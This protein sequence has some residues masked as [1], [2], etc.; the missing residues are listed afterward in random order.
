MKRPTPDVPHIEVTDPA[1]ALRETEK[2]AQ[3]VMIIPKAEVDALIE[4]EKA[5][6]A[7]KKKRKSR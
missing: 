3:K 6:R 1:A 2:L 5:K 4:K 7:A